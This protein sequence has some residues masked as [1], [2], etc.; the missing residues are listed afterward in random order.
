MIIRKKKCIKTEDK[1]SKKT[2]VDTK[3]M[4]NMPQEIEVERWK[5]SNY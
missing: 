2:K 4:E 3:E 1:L 5:K